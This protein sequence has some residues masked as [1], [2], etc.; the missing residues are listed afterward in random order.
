[1][2]VN[3]NEI[4]NFTFLNKHEKRALKVTKGMQGSKFGKT[5]LILGN[6]PSLK[7]LDKETVKVDSPDVFVVNNF[8]ENSELSKMKVSYYFISDPYYF[9]LQENQ[10]EIDSRFLNG[11]KNIDH[12]DM[13]LVVPHW[14]QKLLSCHPVFQNRILYFDDRELLS[15]STSISPVRPRGYISLT[16]YKALAFAK[17]LGY[18]Q[19]FVLGMD[20]SQFLGLS[21]NFD[22]SLLMKDHHSYTGSDVPTVDISG[23][24]P[25]GPAGFLYHYAQTF[26]DLNKFRGEVYNL[27][28]FSLV[29]QFRKVKNHKWIKSNEK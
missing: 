1:M 2:Y 16:L 28:E 14:A 11:M 5:A 7:K 23:H 12:E 24:Y 18:S 6:G 17:Y 13:K 4:L 19:I 26:G 25:D 8:Y 27:D 29:T 21:S 20:N 9:N 15:W 3:I 10:N 22:N